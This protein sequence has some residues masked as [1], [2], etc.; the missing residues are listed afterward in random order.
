[1]A[2]IILF[3]FSYRN[4][5]R[6]ECRFKMK[7]ITFTF[8]K[9]VKWYIDRA[10]IALTANTLSGDKAKYMGAGMEGYL[11]KPIELEA[12]REIFSTYFEEKIIVESEVISE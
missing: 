2:E 4:P 9:I 12:L 1:M 3:I 10:G 6:F 5:Q 8:F 7:L 11:S